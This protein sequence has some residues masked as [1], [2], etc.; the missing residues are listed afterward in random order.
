[1]IDIFTP[2]NNFLVSII[3]RVGILSMTTGATL[4][5]FIAGVVVGEIHA[6]Y[7]KRKTKET[8][9]EWDSVV[10]GDDYNGL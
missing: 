2:P 6:R 9:K 10:R 8:N 5:G 7:N 1:M 4:I 3:E